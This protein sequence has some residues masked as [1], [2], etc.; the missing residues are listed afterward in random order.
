MDRYVANDSKCNLL[1]LGKQFDK[2]GFA[3]VFRKKSRWTKRVSEK[4]LEYQTSEEYR[5][6]TEKWQRG[7][8]YF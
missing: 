4:I 8:R 6:L 1:T 2:N 3:A 5:K 7:R